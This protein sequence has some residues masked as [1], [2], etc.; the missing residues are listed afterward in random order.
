VQGDYLFASAWNS[1]RVFDI[2]D[3]A[4]QAPTF[5]TSAPGSNVHSSWATDDLR[6][7]VTAEERTGGGLTLYEIVE[8]EEPAAVSLVERDTY[9]VPT[10]R[11]TSVHN[12]VIRDYTVYVSWYQIGTQIFEIDPE[13][14]KLALIASFDTTAV[15]GNTGF[16]GNWGVY[17]F[18]G[19]SRLLASDTNTGLWVLAADTTSAPA[20]SV[21]GACPGPVTLSISG[22]TPNAEVAV[23]KAANTNGFEKGGAMCNGS[24]LS[25]GEPFNLPPSFVLTDSN[26]N[27]ST[28][29]TLQ[30]GFCQLQALDFANCRRSNTVSVD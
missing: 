26:G 2:T 3:I 24:L 28:Q 5:L 4:T 7:L 25:I 20:L 22:A 11:A 1:L 18:L 30:S 13:L 12:P 17:P 21:N 29:T 10:S 9:T 27:G 14:K 15:N 8:T 16:S 6:F 23:V 19:D